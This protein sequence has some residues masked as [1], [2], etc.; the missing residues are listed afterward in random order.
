MKIV[1]AT[2]IYPPEVGGPAYYA[3]GLA[4]AFRNA[5][6]TATVVSY[7]G[8]K[9]LPMGVRH[10]VYG[11]ALLPRALSA[12]VIIALDTFSVAVPAAA[13]SIMTRTPL[14][15]RTGGDFLW[16]Q[17]IE[18]TKESIPLPRFYD[19]KRTFTTKER[20]IF[21]LT[22]F[23]LRHAFT[24]FSTEMQRDIWDT[25]YD[26]DRGRTSVIANAVESPLPAI[27]PT[28]KNFLWHV[29]PNAIK[30][31][32]R[33][34]NAFKK[35]RAMNAE[36]ILEEGTMPKAELL[37]RMKSCYAVVLP[38]LTE[39]SPNYI[40]DALRFHKPFIMDKYS[41]LA[42]WLSRYGMVVDP[43]NED[44]IT[45]ALLELATPDGYRHGQEKA[46]AFSFERPYDD[47]AR[48]FLE[49]ISKNVKLEKRP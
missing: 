10:V 2:G 34:H 41:G 47:V 4:D 24:V 25:P 28:A 14:V 19:E 30:N 6:H 12:D 36:I 16:E 33:A 7:G 42:P 32:D 23:A 45:K 3:K 29:R 1:I 22:K 37:E 21:R 38:S 8:L 5:G 11:L 17:Y 20:A 44:E 18:R 9:K 48:D 13:V 35:A 43:L 15:I 46:A 26:L 39:I 31:A 49:L 27:A 40:L